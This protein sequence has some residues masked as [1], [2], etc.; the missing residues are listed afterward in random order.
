[1]HTDPPITAAQLVANINQLQKQVNETEDVLSRLREELEWYETGLQL[2]ADEDS[3]VSAELPLVGL[4]EDSEIE[5]SNGSKP[6]LRN[7]IITVLGQEPRK[8]WKTDALIAELRQRDWLPNGEHAEHHV[9]S[10]VAQMAR[11]GQARKM[12][13]GAYRLP[14][15]RKDGA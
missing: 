14:P 5:S 1:M 12:A 4:S 3:G 6:P 9:R 10:M 15:E 2:F 11:K 8:T 7:R 13:R